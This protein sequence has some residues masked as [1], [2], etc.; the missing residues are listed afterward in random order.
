M[1]GAG[2]G[3]FTYGARARLRVE[4]NDFDVGPNSWNGPVVTRVRGLAPA[5]V[6]TLERAALAVH[7]VRPRLYQDCGAIA[8]VVEDVAIRLGVDVGRDAGVAEWRTET[9]GLGWGEHVWLRAGN[10]LFD[11]KGYLLEL[12]H[13]ARFRQSPPFEGYKPYRP[14]WWARDLIGDLELGSEEA[15]EATRLALGVVR[16]VRTPGRGPGR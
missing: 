9:G 13:P 4:G 14:A 16:D 10:V 1:S 8:Q 11:P 5:V 7:R 15:A 12:A 3:V 6:A 2:R